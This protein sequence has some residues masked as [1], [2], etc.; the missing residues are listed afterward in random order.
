MRTL[1]TRLVKGGDIEA[2]AADI[3]PSKLKPHGEV[4]CVAIQ[5]IL[6]SIAL[7]KL[8]LSEEII[9]GVI[10]FFLILKVSRILAPGRRF[11]HT[12]RH[13]D[14]VIALGLFVRLA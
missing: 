10:L 13:A 3:S 9:M 4:S 11:C 12:W 1:L 5:L 2:H 8:R 14:T 7:K 6:L